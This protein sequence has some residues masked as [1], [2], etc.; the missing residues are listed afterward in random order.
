MFTDEGEYI[1]EPLPDLP[2]LRVLVV[3]DDGMTRQLYE[4]YLLGHFLH[5]ANDAEQAMEF[6]LHSRYE[7]VLSDIQLGGRRTGFDVAKMLR[8]SRLNSQAL[9]I[10]TTANE[11]RDTERRCYDAGFSAFLPKPFYQKDILWLIHDL[12]EE[13][14][15]G[16]WSD[17]SR[18]MSR[19]SL[20]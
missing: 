13:R 17:R 6:A 9:L 8:Q 10:A 3:E 14:P 7:V 16:N 1:P 4:K 12:L 19:P 5:T 15:G 2:R 20:E 18:P 11:D